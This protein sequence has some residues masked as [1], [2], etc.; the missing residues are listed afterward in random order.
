MNLFV[1]ITFLF[2]ISTLF[3]YVN[4]RWIK[5]PGVIG[6]MVLAIVTALLTLVAG[7]A[8]PGFS[9]FILDLSRSIDFSKTLLDVLLGFLLFASAL[10]FDLNKLKENLRG[11]LIISTVGVLL[12]TLLF[13]GLLYF[14]V[15]LIHLPI[16]LI[17]CL[18]FGALISPTD[19][20]AVAALLKKSKMPAR[21][22]TII[23]GESLF[24]DG[25]GLVLF[26]TFLELTE[27]PGKT[28][29]LSVAAQL[30]AQEVFGGIVLGSVMGWLAYR[31]IRSVDD[32]QTIVLIS[33]TLVMGISVVAGLLHVSIPLAVVAAGLLIGSRCF[34][35]DPEHDTKEY[36]EKVWGLMDELLNT[37]L[38]VL[39]GLQMVSVSFSWN[40]LLVG[41]LAIVILLIARGL[42]IILPIVFLRRSLKLQY[43]SIF[44]L[45]W[46]GLRGGISVALALSLPDS[47][48]REI[49]LAG[50]FFIVVFSIV[51]QGLTLNKVVNKLI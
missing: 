14:I 21:L 31:M 6:V 36:L 15:G 7:K 1:I 50:S 49:I 2:A 18:L 41:G 17:Y 13:G 11:V 29:S 4:A 23:S 9:R 33:I 32:F 10:H 45:T 24:N 12:S 38:F 25:I 3:S 19:A 5:L 47:P 46:G 28:F 22:E 30:F 35:K 51:F 48:Y 40:Y 37:I 34:G 20:V 44:I 8:L 26:V 39:I 43:S 42:S 16:P 27:T